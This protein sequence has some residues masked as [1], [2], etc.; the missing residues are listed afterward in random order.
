MRPTDL[1]PVDQTPMNLFWS[2][3][4]ILN[5][6]EIEK[7][8]GDLPNVSQT[9]RPSVLPVRPSCPSLCPSCPS[10]PPFPL[11]LCPSVPLLPLLPLLPLSL[12]PSVP[13]SLCSLCNCRTPD[14]PQSLCYEIRG[15]LNARL[16]K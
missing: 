1:E 3:Q 11:S 16:M 10:I 12:C 13:P 14:S 6:S 8:Q 4:V 9:F 7:L 5:R 2:R 15:N